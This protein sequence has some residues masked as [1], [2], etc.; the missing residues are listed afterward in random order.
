MTADT[1]YYFS[2]S[3]RHI[4]CFP[5]SNEI[6]ILK[7]G[8]YF[9]SIKIRIKLDKIPVFRE[10]CY[11][12]ISF[13]FFFAFSSFLRL[14]WKLNSF[15]NKAVVSILSIA[16]QIV[17]RLQASSLRCREYS[18]GYSF[19]N[20]LGHIRLTSFPRCSSIFMTYLALWNSHLSFL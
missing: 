9:F 6:A 20:P 18:S 2:E 16:V 19:A 12:K 5:F 13:I 4:I 17:E 8:S 11:L 14:F 10:K 15:P 1:L 7:S 3:V